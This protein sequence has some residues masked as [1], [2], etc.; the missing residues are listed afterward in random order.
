MSSRPITSQHPI[1]VVT[2]TTVA[3][4]LMLGIGGTVI[5]LAEL[6]LDSPVSL[7]YAPVTIGLVIWACVTRRWGI[8]GFGRP[9]VRG[10]R[11]AWR[12]VLL[13]MLAV[14]I[15]VLVSTSGAVDQTAGAWFGMIGFVVLVAFV[16][17]T[18]FR[19]VFLRLLA[20]TGTRTAVLVSTGA[21]AL[22]HAVNLLGGQD[23]PSTLAQI[24]FAAAFGLFAACAFLRTGSLWPVLAFHALFDL[25]QLSSVHQTPPAV[26]AVMTVILLGGA[27]WLWTGIRRS[28]AAE[29][30]TADRSTPLGALL[31]VR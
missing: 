15:L 16:E 29:T 6:P 13:P 25:A 28:A 5:Y 9:R 1:T 10:A 24:G 23:L 20:P 7:V 18:L 3:L 2:L 14:F 22:A 31:P 26:D 30:R 17:E 8:L 19:A 12:L 4:I 21:F 11:A 27:V